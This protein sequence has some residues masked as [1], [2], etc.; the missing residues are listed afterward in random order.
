VVLIQIVIR[1]QDP[2]LQGGD[3]IYILLDRLPT[4]WKSNLPQPSEGCFHS[5]GFETSDV[6]YIFLPIMDYYWRY[7]VF[8]VDETLL[9]MC[10]VSVRHNTLLTEKIQQDATVYQNFIIPYFS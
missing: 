6:M 2:S 8:H 9:L 10:R 4:F 7:Q 1:C 3:V 5:G